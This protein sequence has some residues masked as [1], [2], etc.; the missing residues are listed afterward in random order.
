[1]KTSGNPVLVGTGDWGLG[2]GDWGL[3]TG[4]R[5]IEQIF[6]RGRSVMKFPFSFE[7]ARI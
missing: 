7:Q 4:K 2:T 3:G 6:H 1:M 5:L